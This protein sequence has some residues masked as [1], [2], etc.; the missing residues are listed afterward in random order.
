[1]SSHPF[2]TSQSIL[3]ND[4]TKVIN[5][6]PG[7]T[8]GTGQGLWS[9][10]Q[11]GNGYPHFSPI[12]PVETEIEKLQKQ[13]DAQAL[14][15]KLMRLKILGVEGKFTQEEMSNIRKMIM[16]EDEASRTLADSIIENA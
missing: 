14:T 2:N 15:I 4:P 3:V 11:P 16:S 10:I 1:M 13:L 8:T 9:Q 12:D 5:T 7:T 6:I